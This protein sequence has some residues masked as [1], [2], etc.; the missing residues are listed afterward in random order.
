MSLPSSEQN[1]NEPD[2]ENGAAPGGGDAPQ[3]LSE[4]EATQ[5]LPVSIIPVAPMHWRMLA[6]LLDGIL[7]TLFATLLLSKVLL[8]EYH[9]V[10]YAQNQAQ[11]EAYTAALIQA[12]ENKEPM[13][14]PLDYVKETEEIYAM[15]LYGI[16]IFGLCV[17][18]YFV[19]C[20]RLMAGGSLG[21]SMLRLRVISLNT[22]RPPS[23]WESFLRSLIKLCPFLAA[24]PVVNVLL[25]A[26]NYFSPFGN[27]LRRA[28]H[29]WLARTL[30]VSDV[31]GYVPHVAAPRRRAEDDDDDDY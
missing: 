27:R 29:D 17:I 1:Q 4:A 8:P 10:G 7:I 28:G 31:G 24:V 9:P 14:H 25:F 21:K 3:T 16:E 15:Y 30:V 12:L 2:R 11:S 22:G 20:E 18:A 13:P 5:G 19:L 6:F 23:I 26:I